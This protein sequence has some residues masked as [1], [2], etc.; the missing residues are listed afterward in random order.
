MVRDEE[1]GLVEER[2]I[3][4]ARAALDDDGN[5]VRVLLSDV[6]HVL[7]TLNCMQHNYFEEDK[8]DSR[9]F[10]Q[11]ISPHLFIHDQY[12]EYFQLRTIYLLIK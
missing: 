8:T 6:L 4:L 11:A 1:L 5:L 10:S 2:E 9:P 12:C 7:L 3:P